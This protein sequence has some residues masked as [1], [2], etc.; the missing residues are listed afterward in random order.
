MVVSLRE[1]SEYL[2]FVVSVSLTVL[3]HVVCPNS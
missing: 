2:P 1:N 3:L